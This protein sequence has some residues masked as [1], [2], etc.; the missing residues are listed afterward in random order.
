M[1]QA[2]TFLQSA[3]R[4]CGAKAIEAEQV[5]EIAG[6]VPQ[7]VMTNLFATCGEGSFEKVRQARALA[8]VCVC[9]CVC[10]SLPCQFRSVAHFT[11]GI[12]TPAA[13]PCCCAERAVGR[14]LC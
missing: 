1:R 9:L 5:E 14:V 8:C 13:A 12:H 11:I 7:N 10:V 6:A 3:S 2:I 4:L